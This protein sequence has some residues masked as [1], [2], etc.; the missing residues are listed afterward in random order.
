M[1]MHPSYYLGCPMWGNRSWVGSVIRSGIKASEYLQDY[2][3]A[4]NT[5]EG[6]TTFYAVP[7]PETVRMWR[8]HAPPDFRFCF[9]FPRQ[10]SHDLGLRHCERETEA[11]LEAMRPLG[12]RLGPFFLQ[13]PPHFD[14]LD[15]LSQF[16]RWLPKDF[17]FAV[18]VRHPSFFDKGPFERDF[19]GLLAH[20]GMDRVLFD[21]ERLMSFP[22]K[23]DGVRKSQGK[24]PRVPR[25]ITVTGRFPFLR[26]VGIPQ[27]ENDLPG[28]RFWADQAADWIRQG[29]Q[30]YVFM[31]QVPEDD[32]A[33][34][35]CRIFH[36]LLREHLPEL[37]PLPE[38][39][40]ERAA[41]ENEGMR[42][43]LSL[44]D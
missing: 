17:S 10:I 33:P 2:A 41:R 8:E 1:M 26:Y 43:Q 44:F 6:N 7:K 30:P 32:D 31:H 40:G 14:H 11:F 18:E 34:Q 39:P 19:D 23:D 16:L 15:R 36:E 9:K 35:M 38:W 37:P 3:T 22:S 13:L 25:R 29:R 42:R 27:V 21:T 12:P 24:K 20:L 5:V 28:L 4:L